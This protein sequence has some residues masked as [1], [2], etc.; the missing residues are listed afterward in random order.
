MLTTGVMIILV[1]YGR[2]HTPLKMLHTSGVWGIEH[3]T[4]CYMWRAD[5]IWS[6]YVISSTI[7][8][9]CRPN[10]TNN[11]FGKPLLSFLY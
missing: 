2:T 4:S 5:D 7:L 9:V 11:L 3:A 1:A 10:D 8:V 6:I